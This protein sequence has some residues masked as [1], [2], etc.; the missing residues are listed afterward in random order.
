MSDSLPG[1]GAAIYDLYINY[2]GPGLEI[3][4]LAVLIY[5]LLRII[6]R[7]SGGG[8]IKG[9]AIAMAVMLLAAWASQK[10]QLYAIAW[11]LQNV[12]TFSAIILA[13]VFQPE[14]RRLFIRMG[15]F[16]TTPEQ[17]ATASVIEKLVDAVDLLAKERI[18]ALIVLERSDHLDNYV[19][20]GPF[21]CAISV[22]SLQ[23][24]FWKN[25]PVHDGAV[26]IRD[27]RVVAAGV[28]LPLT[29]N[30]EYRALSGTRHRAA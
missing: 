24:I 27:G 16:F 18:G 10:A 23:T 21:D 3:V 25:S 29:Q 4:I 1:S 20:A 8:K 17:A 7:I 9:M 15:R 11:L 26:I 6:D 5:Y 19:A 28:I 13:V 22:R 12:L 2:I 30:Q 14:M